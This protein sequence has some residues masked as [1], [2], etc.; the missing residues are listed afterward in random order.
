MHGAMASRSL[1]LHALTGPLAGQTWK[2]SPGR[3]LPIGRGRNGISLPDPLVSLR[4]AEISQ[5]EGGYSVSDLGS[6][7]GTWVDGQRITAPSLIREG[8]T[9]RIGE[10]CLQVRRRPVAPWVGT[11]VAALVIVTVLGLFGAWMVTRPVHYAPRLGWAT[12]IHMAPGVEIQGLPLEIDFIRQVGLD[13]RVERLALANVTDGDQDGIDEFWIRVNDRERVF[14]FE[15]GSWKP[16]GEVPRECRHRD[17]AGFDELDCDGVIWR[18][19]GHAYRPA[20]QEGV[21]GWMTSGINDQGEEWSGPPIPYRFT[22]NRE[23]ELT[24]FLESRGVTEPVHYL[25]CEEAV[26]GLAA[27]V[28]TESGE[29]QRLEPGCIRQVRLDGPTRREAFGTASPVAVAF[30]GTGHQALIDDIATF[31]GGNTDSLFLSKE[32]LSLLARVRQKPINRLGRERV[33]FVVD[34]TRLDDQ[35]RSPIG[36]ERHMEGTNLL[37]ASSSGKPAPVAV[38]ATLLSEGDKRIPAQGCGEL[39]LRTG[40]FSCALSQGCRGSDNFLTVV[41]SGCE[42][43]PETVLAQLPYRGGIAGG[44]GQR[45]AVNG[46]TIVVDDVEIR[47]MVESVGNWRQVDV[48]R[49]R[50]ALRRSDGRPRLSPLK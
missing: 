3:P 43:K 49:A 10:T 18:F 48:L 22:L 31:L 42:G 6:E 7:T 19:D 1:D 15:N 39:E 41:R 24:Q 14:T 26:P 20:E 21:V 30:T 17:T 40:P 32:H 37:F 46:D 44:G 47:A 36:R 35:A 23:A 16:L 29:I 12:P 5:A 4:H 45:T 25:I 33:S 8:T 2:L 9:V 28:L 27:Q 34:P 38:T 11:L 50:V 13:H